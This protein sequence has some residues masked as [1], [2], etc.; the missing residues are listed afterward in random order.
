MDKPSTAEPP[1]L[2]LG[3]E[4]ELRWR[5]SLLAP[6]D[7]M[8]GLFLNS[9]IDEVRLHLG[10]DAVRRCL[11]EIGE[12]RV[13]DFFNYPHHTLMRL[14]YK[15]SWL[16]AEKLGSFEKG[17]W[18]LGYASCKTFYASA[19]GRVLLLMAQGDPRRLI[20]NVPAAMEA[21][22]KNSECKVS[23]TGPRSGVI[24][25]HDL[26]PRQWIEAGF[27]SLFHI[28]KVKGA[29]VVSRSLGPTEN[30]YVITWE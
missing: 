10:E 7:L 19:A 17:I 1:Q 27:L 5:L 13:L 21:A 25:K 26:M 28:A 8:R 12:E 22:S 6:T 9:V 20:S 4:E 18:E 14:V 24:I 30:E 23:L 15:A 3:T 29:K 16:L 11:E 2:E